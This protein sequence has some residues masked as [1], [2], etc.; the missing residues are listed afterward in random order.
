MLSKIDTRK[1]LE[2]SAYI[3]VASFIVPCI[4]VALLSDNEFI[5][6][7]AINLASTLFGVVFLFFLINRFLGLESRVEE[8]VDQVLSF[9]QNSSQV[10]VN[11]E[12]RRKRL[13]VGAA[14]SEAKEVKVLGNTL[15]GFLESYRELILQ[16]VK[17]GLKIR[18]ILVDPRCYTVEKSSKRWKYSTLK[19]DAQRGLLL[20]E[21]IQNQLNELGAIKGSYEVRRTNWLPT[22]TML[23]Y[24]SRSK[25]GRGSIIINNLNYATPVN[26]SPNLVVSKSVNA[27]WLKFFDQEFELLWNELELMES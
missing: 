14:L 13:P 8:K 26:S 12:G 1:R 2:S 23:L 5:K 6:D 27:N 22:Y 16:R 7:V 10:L 18:L 3:I 15:I 20:A 4:A 19:A 9:T 25:D 17:V 21:N 11:Y 24:D